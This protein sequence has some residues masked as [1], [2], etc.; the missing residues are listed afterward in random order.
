MLTMRMSLTDAISVR[1]VEQMVHDGVERL[2]SMPGVV[3]ASATCCVPI[4]AATACRTSSS[5]AVPP[6]GSFH[7]GGGW[8]TISPS[9]FGVF[10]IPVKRGRAFNERDTQQSPRRRDHQRDH[11]AGSGRRA[12]R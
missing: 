7:G 11:G 5:A 3:A 4:R 9:Y 10:K 6:D 1:G 12:I 8:V 2:R